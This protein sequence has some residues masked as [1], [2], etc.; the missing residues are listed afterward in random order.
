MKKLP[1]VFQNNISKP[2]NN[3][4]KVCCFK[5]DDIKEEQQTIQSTEISKDINNILDE[6]FNGFGYSYNIP[7]EINTKSK[8]YQT[9]LIA[10]TK[11]NLITLDNETIPIA[12]ILNITIKKDFK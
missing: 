10:K 1:K 2:I 9:S 5:I 6:I 4:K 12:E 7:L 8:N 3:N 11:N